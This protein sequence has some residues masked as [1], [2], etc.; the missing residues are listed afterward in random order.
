MLKV[1]A[2]SLLLT[3]LLEGFLA[4][5]WGVGNRRDALLIIAVNAV[6]NPT[7][8]SL[9]YLLGGGA[10]LTAIIEISVVFAEWLIYRRWGRETHPAFLFSLTSNGFSYFGGILIE[11]LYV[12][13]LM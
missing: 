4:L 6:T 11:A 2:V 13:L 9:Y 12:S 5:I 8:V 3:L 1:L 7:A 10:A